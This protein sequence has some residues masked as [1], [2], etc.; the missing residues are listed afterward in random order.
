M[1]VNVTTFQ[2]VILPLSLLLDNSLSISLISSS[3]SLG[4]PTN[5]HGLLVSSSSSVIAAGRRENY[6]LILFYSQLYDLH[7]DCGHIFYCHSIQVLLKIKLFIYNNLQILTSHTVKI[8]SHNTYDG[9]LCTWCIENLLTT[10]TDMIKL[11]YTFF[12]LWTFIGKYT[13]RHLL[14]PSLNL[15]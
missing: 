3:I 15:D 9:Q 11:K 10:V 4:H 13:V 6:G 8:L 7:N 1:S 2:V 5:S 12:L 14:P